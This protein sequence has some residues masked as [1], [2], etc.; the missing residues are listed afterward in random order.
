MVYLTNNS[1]FLKTNMHSL[2]PKLLYMYLGNFPKMNDI[3]WS[4]YLLTSAASTQ[5]VI[6]L[7]NAVFWAFQA[8][9]Q[10]LYSRLLTEPSRGT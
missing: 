6:N 10:W 9:P 3:L 1:V 2:Y 8:F 7:S 5:N 4:S